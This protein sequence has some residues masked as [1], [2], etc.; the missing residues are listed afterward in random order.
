MR[1]DEFPFRGTFDY[2][3]PGQS[4]VTAYLVLEDGRCFTGS[5]L[6]APR[7][8]TGEIVF[9]TGLT[10]YQEIL[11]DPSYRGQI[12]TLTYPH[13]GNYGVNREDVES[14]RPM[15]EA[16]V[17]HERSPI[18]SNHR[19]SGTLDAYLREND[20]PAIFGI[21]TRALT[22]HIRSKGAM[23]A[24]LT[25]SEAPI[26]KHVAKAGGS[27]AMVGADLVKE[28]S[29]REPYSWSAQSVERFHVVAYDLGI[30]RGILRSLAARGIRVTV[31]PA[32]TPAS[33]TLS[34]KPDGVLFSNGPGDPEPLDYVVASAR[35]LMERLP[36]FGICL[37]HQVL[38]LAAGGR[39]YKLPFGHHGTNHPVKRSSDGAVEITSQNHGFAV[40]EDS[41]RGLPVEL[42]HF[43]LNDGT[44]EGFRFKNAPVMSVQ[45]HPE[46]SPGPHDARYLF[47]DFVKMLERRKG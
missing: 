16:L 36:V 33:E 34:L 32:S 38:A 46:A 42:T 7:D 39:T 21:D 47:D 14:E 1:S 10:G 20:I 43:N 26:E 13:I 30:K 29:C 27:R 11:T 9:N 2:N 5:S 40:E 24:L 23:R 35:D 28:V 45:Y 44:L 8:A 3:P 6:G 41:L 19:A 15:V 37:G 31:V 18:A 17:V 25:T 22:R 12:V 4:Q